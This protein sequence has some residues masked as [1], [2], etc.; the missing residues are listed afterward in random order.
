MV[1]T[2]IVFMGQRVAQAGQDPASLL[3]RQ[4]SQ[5]GSFAFAENF[6]SG[7]RIQKL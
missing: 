7:H 4:R 3:F 2:Y 5:E 1:P 6:S